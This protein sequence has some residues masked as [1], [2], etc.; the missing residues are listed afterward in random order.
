MRSANVRSTCVR[1]DD[2]PFKYKTIMRR[3][4]LCEVNFVSPQIVNW[5]PKKTHQARNAISVV[6]TAFVRRED[7]AVITSH[8]SPVTVPPPTEIYPI[9]S[10]AQLIRSPKSHHFTVS[11][12]PKTT[13]DTSASPRTRSARGCV[14]EVSKIMSMQTKWIT[15]LLGQSTQ[16]RHHTMESAMMTWLKARTWL[17]CGTKAGMVLNNSH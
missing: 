11:I 4:C 14:P 9:T 2:C 17:A 12:A 13:V 7:S 10:L 8:R 3:C 16:A 5:V 1:A 6:A 15:R